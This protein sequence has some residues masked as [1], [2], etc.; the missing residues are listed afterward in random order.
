MSAKKKTS[1]EVSAIAARLVGMDDDKIY[2]AVVGETNMPTASLP[3]AVS[4]QQFCRDVR[5][6]AA[7]ALSQDEVKGR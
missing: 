1:P 7:S 2:E 3:R 5:A 6:V 4:F